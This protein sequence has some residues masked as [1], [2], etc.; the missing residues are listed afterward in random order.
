MPNQSTLH[1]WDTIEIEPM[2]SLIG[3]Q[4]VTGT[5]TML[6]RILL[7]QGAH[8]PLHS[9]PNEQIAYVLSGC[10]KFVLHEPD[11]VRSVTLRPGDVLCIPPHL[12]HEA[13]ALEDTIDL[14]IFTPP[15]Q[16]WIDRD[17]AYLRHE[18]PAKPSAD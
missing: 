6:A 15:R 11:S 12:P 1:N 5:H 8:V 9:H 4:F 18:P 3:R 10:L 16:D 17:D 2:N 14:D 13:F 7:K